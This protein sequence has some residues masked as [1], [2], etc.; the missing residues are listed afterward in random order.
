MTTMTATQARD[1]LVRLLDIE[2]MGGR[3]DGVATWDD[4]V[5][6]TA[7]ALGTRTLALR[8]VER[9]E[10][11]LAAALGAS[12]DT[13]WPVLVERAREVSTPTRFGQM[14]ARLVALH[15]RGEPREDR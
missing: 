6:Y 14:V 13:P 7:K 2:P 8:T 4:V 3:P 10:A 12:H 1:E 15:R 5:A 11:A 9:R